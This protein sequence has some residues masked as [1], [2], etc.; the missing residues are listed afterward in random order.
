M[1]Q[2]PDQIIDSAGEGAAGQDDI[3][4]LLQKAN[5]LDGEFWLTG[6]CVLCACPDC[7]AP[8]TVRLW[9]MVADCWQCGTSIEL[10]EEQERAIDHLLEKQASHK[11]DRSQPVA[12]RTQVP[13]APR[14]PFGQHVDP[15]PK[16]ESGSFPLASLSSQSPPRQ[17]AP[18]FGHVELP[19][20]N[21]N[22][23]RDVPAWLASLIIHLLMLMLLAL[24]VMER[25]QEEPTITLSMAVSKYRQ[26]GDRLARLADETRFDLPAP[27]DRPPRNARDLAALVRAD[28]EARP[29]R[30]DPD[31]TDPNLV[32]LNRVKAIIQSQESLRRP[33][34]TRDP[35]L[36]REMIFQEGGT[37]LTEAAVARG[38]L[39]LATQQNPL[40]SWG[41]DGRRQRSAG[42]SLAL[43]PFLGAGQ[44][45]LVGRY[46]D[47]VSGGLRYLLESQKS[48]GDLRGDAT[49]KYGMYVHG[50][51]AI[52]LCETYAMTHDERFREPAQRS[53]EFIVAAQY[54]RG[55]WRYQPRQE[56]RTRSQRGDTSVVGWQVMALQSARAAGLDVPDEALQLAHQFLDLVED[57]NGATYAYQQGGGS[58]PTMTAEGLLCRMYLGWQRQDPAL[59]AGI[60]YLLDRL[61]TPAQTDYYYWYYA[62]QVVHHT[63][64]RR[65][66]RWNRAIRNTLVDTQRTRGS[67]AGSW[68]ARGHHN[69]GEL[70]STS[71]AICTLEV[72]YRHA[73]I[74]RRIVLD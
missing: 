19:F 70:Y 67:D 66:E 6:E 17:I 21:S 4:S 57:D 1:T 58:T 30:I 35:R 2:R 59:D 37:S 51:A 60:N 54:P 68:P 25:E 27:D 49:H 53:I 43:L 10:C 74:F 5:V 16:I 20:G 44:T 38:L 13:T 45:H 55:G 7:D 22:W 3:G 12:A 50:Q 9:L 15:A 32:A 34:A 8:M 73:P 26:E 47:T 40:G 18:T 14:Q 46:K 62:T 64:G 28:Q 39:W 72:Y 41:F 31:S 48:D 61:P 33:L 63:G 69:A 11:P 24:L 23:L 65:W 42:T 56:L 36:R 71:L 52:V 29:L